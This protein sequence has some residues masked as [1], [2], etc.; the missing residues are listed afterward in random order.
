M[1]KNHLDSPVELRDA[2]EIKKINPP[3]RSQNQE[4]EGWWICK[5]VLVFKEF[6]SLQDVEGWSYHSEETQEVF[7]K[8]L[9][10]RKQEEATA[11][12]HREAAV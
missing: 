11:I 4:S 1:P 3:H 6:I 5:N 8:F 9:D 10:N 12:I 7:I 2:S